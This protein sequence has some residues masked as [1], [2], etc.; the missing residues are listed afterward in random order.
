MMMMMMMMIL[1]WGGSCDNCFRQQ[2][3]TL[4]SPRSAGPCLP[5]CCLGLQGTSKVNSCR[6]R[7]F[8]HPNIFRIFLCYQVHP[9]GRLGREA[10]FPDHSDSFPKPTQVSKQ[11][12]CGTKTMILLQIRVNAKKQL[13]WAFHSFSSDP[14]IVYV[15]Q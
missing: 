4:T 1:R 11:S 8:S 10:T 6:S 9:E 14:I 12:H 3:R 15:C 7:F 5:F 2:G 13:S